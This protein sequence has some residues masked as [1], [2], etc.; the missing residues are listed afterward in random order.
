[1]QKLGILMRRPLSIGL[2]T[3]AVAAVPLAT[4]VSA[5]TASTAGYA[6]GASMR[7][8]G[9]D[10]AG[11]PSARLATLPGATAVHLGV[12]LND[13]NAAGAQTAVNAIYQVGS[14]TYHQFFTPADYA[15]KYGV[16][17]AIAA[18]TQ[19]WATSTGMKVGFTS[20]TRDYL[21]LTGTAAQAD[22]LLKIS[23]GTYAGKKGSYTA[24]DTD[25]MV[26]TTLPVTGILGLDSLH[27]STLDTASKADATEAVAK[28]AAIGRAPQQDG[29]NAPSICTGLTRPQDLWSAYD[30]P[31]DNRGAGQ[32]VAIFGEGSVDETIDS[33][34]DFEKFNRFRHVNIGL[35]SVADDFTSED[36]TDEWQ[37]D[38]QSSTGMAPDLA[39]EDLYFGNDL[40]DASTLAVAQAWTGDANAPLQASASY[41]ECE[42]SPM[43][44]NTSVAPVTN[45]QAS[46][47]YEGAYEKT[48]MM[49]AA[50]GRTLFTSAGD[51]GGG[52]AET[53]LP[54]NGLVEEAFPLAPYPAGSAYAVGVGGTILS[55]DHDTTSDT[56]PS[57]LNT[58]K[59]DGAM[60]TTAPGEVGWEYTGGGSSRFIAMPANDYQA[61]R[62]GS[63][64][65]PICL[66]SADGS[67]GNTGK[68]C[69][70]VPDIAAQSGDVATMNGYALSAGGS[71]DSQGAGTSL[72]S[73]LAV[74]MWAR[75]QAAAPKDAEGNF[76]GLGFANYPFYSHAADFH[77]ITVGTTGTTT[78]LP[79]Y[80]QMT[81][82]GVMDVSK[83]MT[84]LDGGTT[85]KNSFFP[86][87][88]PDPLQHV[89]LGNGLITDPTGDATSIA[90]LTSL[91]DDPTGNGAT[92]DQ[93]LDITTAS[94]TQDAAAANLTFHVK[95]VNLSDATPP[96]QYFRFQF[97][98]AGTAYYVLLERSASGALTFSLIAT[99]AVGATSTTVLSNLVGTFDDAKNE[100]S[101]V[102][103][104][105][106][107]NTMGM[108]KPPLGAGGKLTDLDL[109]GQRPTGAATLTADEATSGGCPYTLTAASAGSTT[110]A[111]A[112]ATAAKNAATAKKTVANKRRAA[113]KEAVVRH[114]S[115]PTRTLAF[116]GIDAG[117]PFGALALLGGGLLLRRRRRTRS[118]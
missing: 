94:I 115:Q 111:T 10:A 107:F 4:S 49:A 101:V 54:A 74:G 93:G 1:M 65:E 79:G 59:G 26:P 7:L 100:A 21:L 55:T 112:T 70:S 75:I 34:R 36:G 98:Y 80:D 61:G 37:L 25:P 117:V 118:S 8:A 71:D 46:V 29:C 6:A 102:V 51:T 66:L 87:D 11:I 99:G 33:L 44:D 64:A 108:L 90:G 60:R 18:S 62:L 15:A 17:P 31:D 85:P 30:Q 20:V 89:C 53:S 63:V 13:V 73:P 110:V 28:A 5:A 76:S 92:D 91:P 27:S 114:P 35:R 45:D 14:P 72:S 106:A 22:S 81:G 67:T 52:C 116:T 113:H 109:L 84:D 40:S 68:K 42:A 50:E 23:L 86:A 83:L 16:D 104:I 39:E 95:V 57:S 58:T 41:G 103:P 19:T 24:A 43:S 82:L 105:A 97:G 56:D 32:K 96:G 48:L 77:D 9:F 78:A 47:T 88:T 3:L 12:V 69:K 2:L 38:T